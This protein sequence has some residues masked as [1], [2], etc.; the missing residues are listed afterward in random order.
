M[1]FFEQTFQTV[2]NGVSAAPL[3][4]AELDTPLTY[5]DMAAI[6]SG[7]GTASLFVVGDDTDMTAVAAGISRFL[8]VESCGQCTPC[9]F[10]GLA[11]ADSLT[12]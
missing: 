11:I 1:F 6:G 10:D 8:A 12:R 4:P 3:T 2:L 7:L 5:E 9:K